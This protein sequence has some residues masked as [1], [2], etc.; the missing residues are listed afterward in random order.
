MDTHT[1]T[2][3]STPNCTQTVAIRRA[4]LCR[5][6]YRK[7]WEEEYNEPCVG[8]SCVRRATFR[9]SQL[10]QPHQEQVLLGMEMKVLVEPIT[11]LALTDRDNALQFLEEQVVKQDGCWLWVAG[12]NEGGYGIVTAGYKETKHSLAH[13]LM[14]HVYNDEDP[15]KLSVHHACANRACV[16]PEHLQLL[17]AKEN[18]AEMLE[19]RAYR[20]EIA[21][22]REKLRQAEESGSLDVLYFKGEDG[23]LTPVRK[24]VTEYAERRGYLVVKAVVDTCISTDSTER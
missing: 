6:H 24:V 13:R 22:L 5:P 20:A 16:N 2:T 14:Y 21:A 17:T 12:L 1:T 19:R 7:R 10:C 15:G 9:K 18:T 8:P 3:C 4:G 11:R 23:S